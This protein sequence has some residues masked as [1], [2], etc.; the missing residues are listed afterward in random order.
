MASVSLYDVLLCNYE[1]FINLWM[2][3][4]TENLFVC[5]RQ[6]CSIT[7]GSRQG[8]LAKPLSLLF[9]TPRPAISSHQ[10]RTLVCLFWSENLHC[11]VLT[12]QQ[13]PL[14]L[15]KSALSCWMYPTAQIVFFP[16]LPIPGF[17]PEWP[18]CQQAQC[19][20]RFTVKHSKSRPPDLKSSSK[21]NLP[22]AW[23]T[24]PA[25][26]PSLKNRKLIVNCI[27]YQVSSLYLFHFFITI[28]LIKMLAKIPR[29]RARQLQLATAWSEDNWGEIP[30]NQSLACN[31]RNLV[32]RIW[33]WCFKKTY[34]RFLLL[35]CLNNIE[36]IFSH[37]L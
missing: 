31:I 30:M 18:Y 21:L 15:A 35:I 5:N 20:R 33:L 17:P 19:R 34:I 32:T 10:H 28:Q 1:D 24:G 3:E 6:Y 14:L 11:T 4:K 12:H 23:I 7:T 27:I 25:T 22:F 16:H 36:L 26:D 2:P 37:I 8:S 29:A 13:I 9:L